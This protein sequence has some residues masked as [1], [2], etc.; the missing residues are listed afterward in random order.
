MTE[1]PATPPTEPTPADALAFG[2][3]PPAAARRGRQGLLVGAGAAVLAVLAGVA[4]YATT[5]LSGGG[6]QP[7]E[8]VPRA[9]FSYLKVDLDPAANQKLAARAFFGKF[10]KLKSATGDADSVF[11]G[12]LE[13]AF[14]GATDLKFGAD[15][16]PW[17]DRRAAV[18]AFP[19]SN[20]TEIVAAF[21][22]KDDAKARATL[23]RL[24]TE[25]AA[26]DKVAYAITKGYVLVSDKQAT[27]DDAVRLSAQASLRDNPTYRGDVARLAG[28]QIAVGW[29]DVAQVF[30]AAEGALVD[31]S[32]MG[33]GALSGLAK[34]RVV[35][36]LHLTNDY[37]E[38]QG[39][40]VGADQKAA[41]KTG[42]PVLLQRLPADTVA[43]VSF[44]D[45]GGSLKTG[46][47]GAGGIPGVN[48]LGLVEGF[49]SQ[50]G[51]SL[52]ADVLP[53]LGSQTVLALGTPFTSFD[54]TPEVGLVATVDPTKA[55]AAKEK[56]VAALAQ[57]GVPAS[58]ELKGG[59]FYLGA[60]AGYEA[61]LAKGGSL[62]SA[63]AFTKAMGDLGAVSFALYADMRAFLGSSPEPALSPL[64]SLGIVAG[65][66][67]GEQFFR[68]RLVAE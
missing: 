18:A 28:D 51:I 46:L 1:T 7:D 21:R 41:P 52:D 24:N 62:G 57:L 13:Q 68:A 33:L 55:A 22:S 42:D 23:D 45:L 8:V 30:H 27:V 38:V 35:A 40:T 64:R 9:T 43:A 17:F 65:V 12:V 5:A 16:K 50:S 15:V 26:A 14:S 11:D 48:P 47:A 6:T 32:G 3:A 49:L 2:D 10:P 34:G 56:V 58:A 60:P 39:R 59:T 36:G 63:P 44:Q 66:R 61:T 31:L 53:L 67:D 37:A 4:V 25:A 29:A 20:G 54:T 19:G